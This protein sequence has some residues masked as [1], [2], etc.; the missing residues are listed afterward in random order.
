MPHCCCDSIHCCEPY[1]TRSSEPCGG[2][3][4]ECGYCLVPRAV[5]DD[6]TERQPPCCFYTFCCFCGPCRSLNQMC[7]WGALGVTYAFSQLRPSSQEF[8]CLCWLCW[9][10]NSGCCPLPR[11]GW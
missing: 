3:W 8:C 11:G 9:G 10:S 5:Q 6:T 1:A 7:A 4:R 2:A